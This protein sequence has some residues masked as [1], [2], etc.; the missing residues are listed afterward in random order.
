MFLT[1]QGQL[2]ALAPAGVAAWVAAYLASARLTADEDHVE[3]RNLIWR[4]WRLSR[5]DL[6]TSVVED[7]GWPKVVFTSAGRNYA[8]SSGQFPIEDLNAFIV[9]LTSDA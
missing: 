7:G 4:E 2:A 5:R 6:T 1:F 3:R 9:Q 8:V